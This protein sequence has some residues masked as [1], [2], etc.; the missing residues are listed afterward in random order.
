L[1]HAIT[2][3][4]ANLRVDQAG[5]SLSK[6]NALHSAG[7]LG[8]FDHV[9]GRFDEWVVD[10]VVG[11]EMLLGQHRPALRSRMTVTYW[12]WPCACDMNN[13]SY[14]GQSVIISSSRSIIWYDGMLQLMK[15]LLH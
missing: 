8:S 4:I 1:F 2:I 3:R 9:L 6:D 11:M 5:T 12:H 10:V 7:F 13:I 14:A 15:V